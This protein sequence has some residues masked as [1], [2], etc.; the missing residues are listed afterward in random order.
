MHIVTRPREETIR[1]EFNGKIYAVRMDGD[2]AFVPDDL[3]WFMCQR[4]L[5]GRGYRDDPKPQWE[6]VGKYGHGDLIPKYQHW[7]KEIPR[8]DVD[9]TATPEA[10]AAILQRKVK[11]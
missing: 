8:S 9:D 4:G 5:V 1:V 2:G 7:C 11:S 10:V 3:G 6:K